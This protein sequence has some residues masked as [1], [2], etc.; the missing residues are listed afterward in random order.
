MCWI[1]TLGTDVSF[2]FGINSVEGD[3]GIQNSLKK[4]RLLRD[5]T[6]RKDGMG[7]SPDSQLL[8]ARN[9]RGQPLWGS[10]P[11]FMRECPDQASKGDLMWIP[12]NCIWE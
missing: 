2:S 7:A 11:V 6:P 4:M 9:M 3:E 5:K 1:I 8:P 12:N 10:T